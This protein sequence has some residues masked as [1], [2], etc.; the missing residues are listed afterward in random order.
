MNNA[1]DD[2]DF[3]DDGLDSLPADALDELENTAIR[4]TQHQNPRSTST[5]E[6]N[7]GNGEEDEVIDLRNQGGA[8]LNN[9]MP[10]RTPAYNQAHRHGYTRQQSATQNDAMDLDEPP[11]RSQA[12]PDQLLLRIRKVCWPNINSIDGL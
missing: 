3:D 7:Y 12:D 5:A 8:H 1:D 9:L 11:R 6:N 10:H 2:F 4:A